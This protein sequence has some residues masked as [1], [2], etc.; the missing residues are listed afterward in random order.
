[1]V[2]IPMSI[3]NV[4][5]NILELEFETDHITPSKGPDRS[6]LSIH[7]EIKTTAGASQQLIAAKPQLVV[8]DGLLFVGNQYSDVGAPL[9][10]G[11]YDEYGFTWLG[12][13]S[14]VPVNLTFE[15]SLGYLHY[16]EQERLKT[17]PSPGMTLKL[18]LWGYVAMLS[19]ASGSAGSMVMSSIYTSAHDDA[20]FRIA[21]S[22]WLD[23]ILPGLGYDQT[24]LIEIPLPQHDPAPVEL[25]DAVQLLSQ[26]RQHIKGEKYR[27]AVQNCR[28]AKDALLKRNP[29]GLM[30]LLEPLVGPTKAA[31]A[32]NAL[33]AFQTIYKAAS[34]PPTLPKDERV[35]VSRD[36][37]EFVVNSLAFILDYVARVLRTQS[38]SQP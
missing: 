3:A 5:N 25:K 26:A 33:V 37:A 23:R 14:G 13:V 16:L 38:A 18:K 9:R 34:H 29:N 12:Q 6:L 7:A 36:D 31:M 2:R 4:G 11:R 32:D 15:V 10:P 24:L 20:T 30:S 19:T 35:E 1:M 17:Q 21:R 8:L 27:E 22:D 28:Q